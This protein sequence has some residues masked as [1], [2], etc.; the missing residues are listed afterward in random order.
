VQVHGLLLALLRYDTTDLML[1]HLPLVRSPQVIRVA[2]QAKAALL[3]WG[4]WLIHLRHTPA[5]HTDILSACACW[6]HSDVN[7]LAASW[8]AS[9]DIVPWKQILPTL[10]KNHVL[11]AATAARIL[12]HVYSRCMLLP[13]LLT[14]YL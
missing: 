13:L 10:C 2:Q 5:S 14:L 11:R 4:V 7:T 8:L 9:Q 6:L 12:L 1:L 3:G